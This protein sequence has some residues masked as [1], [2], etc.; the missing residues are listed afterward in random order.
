M[1][2][3]DRTYFNW[4]KPDRRS[5]LRRKNKVFRGMIVDVRF[6]GNGITVEVS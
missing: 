4:H 1:T 5:N 2:K 3:P 6:D